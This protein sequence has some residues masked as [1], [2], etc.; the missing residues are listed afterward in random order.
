MNK[1]INGINCSVYRS[2]RREFTYLYVPASTDF[3]E[4]PG[5]LLD[6]FG[7]P[8]HVVTFDLTPKRK[9]AQENPRTVLSN[10]AEQ[11]FHLQL[12]PGEEPGDLL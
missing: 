2:A 9:L 1:H 4:L 8:E 12:P 10:I 3:D 11:G 7:T 6:A 5:A